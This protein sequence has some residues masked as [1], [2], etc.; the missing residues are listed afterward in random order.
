MNFRQLNLPAAILLSVFLSACADT[1]SDE[2]AFEQDS[3]VEEGTHTDDPIPLPPELTI[4]AGDDTII[5]VLG[6]YSWSVENQDGTLNSIEA[7]ADG[8]PELVRMSEPTQV[9]EDATIEFVFEEEPRTYSVRIWDEDNTVI[10]ES[11]DLVLSGT[12]DVIYE[13]LAFWEQGTASYAF[14]LTIE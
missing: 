9:T 8:P 10:S 12:G 5:P 13:V 4:Q 6:S 3:A 1:A 11:N 14:S 2:E 7:S